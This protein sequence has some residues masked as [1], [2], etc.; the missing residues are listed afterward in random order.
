M[1]TTQEN[2]STTLQNNWNDAIGV[3]KN[4][5]QWVTTRPDIEAWFKASTKNYLAACYAGGTRETAV[6]QDTWRVDES[7]IIDILIKST[8]TNFSNMIP[9]RKTMKDEVKRIIHSQQ[10]SITGVAL[11]W[12]TR[13]NAVEQLR[14]LRQTL[15]VNCLSFH[16]K[17]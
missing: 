9:I 8:E 4:D 13:E 7:I 11:A 5:V 15:T 1:P 14:L 16:T 2:V 17:T 10:T 3:A 12:I 6:A